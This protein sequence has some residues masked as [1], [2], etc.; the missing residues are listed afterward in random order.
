MNTSISSQISMVMTYPPCD[1]ANGKPVLGLMKGV[2]LTPGTSPFFPSDTDI[3][4][5]VNV[6]RHSTLSLP[7]WRRTLPK[8]LSR[9]PTLRHPFIGP[10]V[11]IRSR[12]WDPG[13]KAYSLLIFYTLPGKNSEKQKVPTNSLNS[14][15]SHWLWQNR[16]FAIFKF[17]VNIFWLIKVNQS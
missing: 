3:Q 16:R 5:N 14:S 1:K 6:G 12:E 15:K 2:F 8:I 10:S 13:K 11:V 9:H 17:T 7:S 4:T